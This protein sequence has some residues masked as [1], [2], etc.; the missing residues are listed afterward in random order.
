MLIRRKPIAVPTL[1]TF[2]LG[3]AIVHPT[4][5]VC[6]L[7][8]C[9]PRDGPGRIGFMRDHADALVI[10]RLAG[11]EKYTRVVHRRGVTR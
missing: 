7:D 2:V 5:G 6:V 9:V 4:R 10:S 1:D 8:A 11:L 3:D